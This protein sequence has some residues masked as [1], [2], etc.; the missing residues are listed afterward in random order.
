M[1]NKIVNCI[2]DRLPL[3]ES[4]AKSFTLDK[5]TIRGILTYILR[6]TVYLGAIYGLKFIGLIDVPEELMFLLP[7][8]EKRLKQ[9]ATDYS[10][11]K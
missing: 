4:G 8:V 3:Q 11:D 10:I 5:K 7:E 9:L 1:I 2:V 6:A